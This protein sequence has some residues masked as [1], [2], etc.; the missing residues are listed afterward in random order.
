MTI[1]NERI[2]RL[3]AQVPEITAPQE[4]LE[5]LVKLVAAECAIICNEV[6][7]PIDIDTWAAMTKRQHGVYA[8]EQCAQAI[9][10]KFSVGATEGG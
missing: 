7:Y 8:C 9:V 4:A 3:I 6:S 5:Q 1:V 10:S 2:Q